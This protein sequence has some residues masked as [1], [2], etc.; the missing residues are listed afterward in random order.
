MVSTALFR[1]FLSR[2]QAATMW[3]SSSTR[4]D[5]VLLGPCMPQP[6]MPMVILPDGVVLPLRARTELGRIVG[7]IMAAPA[8]FKNWRRS[9]RLA[10]GDFFMSGQ[11]E[12]AG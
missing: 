12:V 4:N 7:R 2:S 10:S 5:L 8:A 3:Q 6:T 11:N 1:W 9:R